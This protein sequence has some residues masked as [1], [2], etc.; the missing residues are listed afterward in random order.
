[1]GELDRLLDSVA[2]AC[3]MLVE[4]KVAEAMNRYNQRSEGD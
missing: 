4:G 1:V 2:E 3:E